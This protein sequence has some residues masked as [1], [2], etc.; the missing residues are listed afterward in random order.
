MTSNGIGKPHWRLTA[1]RSMMRV[2]L[3]GKLGR[4]LVIPGPF[5]SG[6]PFLGAELTRPRLQFTPLR[7]VP[8][9]GD[10]NMESAL[11]EWSDNSG[12]EQQAAGAVQAA[13][14]V[15][16]SAQD[17]FIVCCRDAHG[18]SYTRKE[19]L[20][21]MLFAKNCQQDAAQDDGSSSDDGESDSSSASDAD[22]GDGDEFLEA[23]EVCDDASPEEKAEAAKKAAAHCERRLIKRERELELTEE[24]VEARAVTTFVIRFIQELGCQVGVPVRCKK[25]LGV[26]GW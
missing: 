17:A 16:L 19:A 12:V 7:R 5:V 10:R 25:G 24:T 18:S 23:Y 1:E 2:L 9:P 26:Y 15:S 8:T 3:V 22:Y 20:E 21:V 6:L 13:I 4:L 14:A 11:A